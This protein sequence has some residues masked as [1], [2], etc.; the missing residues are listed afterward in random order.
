M[1]GLAGLDWSFSSAL[2]A[3]CVPGKPRFVRQ[4]ATLHRMN[5]FLQ[6]GLRVVHVDRLKPEQAESSGARKRVP[7]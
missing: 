6:F 5:D 7:G 2:G 1:A 4:I 3:V